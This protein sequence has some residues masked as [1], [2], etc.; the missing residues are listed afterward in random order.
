[1]ART[2]WF[3]WVLFL[4]IN[5]LL[6]LPR[7]F[8]SRMGMLEEFQSR[9]SPFRY[10]TFFFSRES[11]DI[12][13]ISMELILLLWL[14][15][16]FTWSFKR[17]KLVFGWTYV[18]FMIYMI[19]D[20][21]F[22]KL[23][24][25]KPIL[26][27]DVTL[28]KYGVEIIWSDR[29]LLLLVGLLGLVGLVW[30]VFR[31]VGFLVLQFRILRIHRTW[32]FGILS[33]LCLISLYRLHFHP[34]LFEDKRHLPIVEQAS[35]NVVTFSVMRNVTQSLALQKK[36]SEF[37]ITSLSKKNSHLNTLNIREK[38]NIFLVFVESYGKVL[39]DHEG[40]S[41]PYLQ[42]LTQFEDRLREKEVRAFSRF[43]V[44]PVSGGGSWLAYTSML[45]G[46]DLA[47]QG[48]Y[49]KLVNDEKFREVPNFLK[50][51]RNQGYKSIFLSP[52]ATSKRVPD[53]GIYGEF[54]GVDEWVKPKVFE[55]F[56][57]TRY[58]WGSI[59]PDQYL[60]HYTK[61]HF[62]ET[63]RPNVLFFLTKNSHSPFK[64]PARAVENWQI[65]E[66]RTEPDQAAY[67]SD[68]PTAD[69]YLKSVY[70]ELDYLTRF[71]GQMNENDLLILVG[72]HQPPVITKPT[73]GSETMIHLLSKNQELVE[74]FEEYGFTEGLRC[75]TSAQ[76]FS[77]KDILWP[78]VTAIT[79]AYGE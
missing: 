48:L 58:G 20:A 5:A 28:I 24:H 25:F 63:E 51:L 70:Y 59:P 11:D 35:F 10:L 40:I 77:H 44:S 45:Y 1:M 36:V 69:D 60:F 68:N 37:D 6:F 33:I 18:F 65:L 19:Y 17:T 75:Q 67:F 34:L 72:D 55:G 41:S 38:P 42:G 50:W 8:V 61:E 21:S 14:S 43:S 39:Y 3:W 9:V 71:A 30:V 62:F 27:N 76:P 7:S 23:Y 26:A 15:V 16:I 74:S 52:L 29:P 49:Q 12:F 32:G 57:G 54:Y 53:Y 78:L 46:A 79:T 64:S 4:T 2:R 56:E 47:T 73:D 66:Q 31:L 13:R 22:K